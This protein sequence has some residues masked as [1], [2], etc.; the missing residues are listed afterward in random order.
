[1]VNIEVIK[2][3]LNQ[4][5]TSLNKIERFKEISLEE[6]LK[7]DI[8]QDVVEYNLFIAIN[9]MIDIATHIV[10]DNNMGSPET[11]GEAFNILNKEKYLNDEETKAYRNMVGL[12][13]ILSHEYINID[14]NII[15][16][17][18]KNNLI[19]IKKFIIFVN[20]NFI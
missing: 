4:L 16:S 17:I 11:L 7:D 14:K 18:L 12:R 10:V 13:N 3:R 6:F 1:M 15:H 2:Q 5:S 9:M 20:D 8:I 19:D